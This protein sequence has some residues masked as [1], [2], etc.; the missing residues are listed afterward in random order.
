MTYDQAARRMVRS[1]LRARGVVDPAVLEAMARV[2]RHR[3]T[4]GLSPEVAYGDHVLPI[5]AGQTISQPYIVAHMTETLRVRPEMRVLEIGTGSGYQT[6]VL[7]TLGAAVVSVERHAGLSDT[8]RRRLDAMFPHADLTLVVGDG[9][10]GYAEAA[11]Y[12]RV[13][14]AAAAP[15]LPEALGEQLAPDGRL[16]IPIGERGQQVLVIVERRGD[17]LVRRDDLACRFVPLIG[18]DAWPA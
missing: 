11:P 14:V 4:P 15:S 6:A 7:L 3:F 18:A 2:E 5:D 10:C 16:V 13:L 8:A 9:S 17:E 1:Q 12:D